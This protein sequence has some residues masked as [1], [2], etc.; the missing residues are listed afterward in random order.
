MRTMRLLTGSLG[1][2]LVLVW[3]LV[4]RLASAQIA[5]LPHAD[6]SRGNYFGAAVA[7]DGNRILVGAH[8]GDQLR[9]ERRGRLRLRKTLSGRSLEKD[10]PLDGG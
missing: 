5:S 9:R 3:M 7:I 10:C 8:G 2:T 4:P 1:L 6:T